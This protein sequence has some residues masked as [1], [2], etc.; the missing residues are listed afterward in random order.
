M[1]KLN[2]DDGGEIE[3]TKFLVHNVDPL[4]IFSQM[5]H[6]FELKCSFAG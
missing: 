1:E 2:R 3:V 4:E 6:M 5:A